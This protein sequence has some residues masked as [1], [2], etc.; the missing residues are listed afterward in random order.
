M[1]AST[2]SDP[3]LDKPWAALWSLVIG[4]FMILVDS[5][6]V[7]I[8]MP[9]IISGLGTDLNG[10]IWVTSAYLLAYVVP[11]LIT[12]RL[13]D[14]IGP[15]TMYLTG[16]AV[17]TASSLACGLAP[18]LTVMIIARV[19]QG[20]GAACMTPQTMTAITR[21]F[22]GARRGPAMAVWGA[23]A[24]VAMLVGP[25]LGGVLTDTLGWSWIF[26][27]N[28]PVGVAG[29]ALVARNVP[30]FEL[31]S[32]AFDLVGVGLSAVAMFLLVFGI[33]EGA[34][35]DWRW[36]VWTMIG[37]GLAML[38]VFVWWQFRTEEPLIPPALFA[39]RNFTLSNT[40]IACMGFAVTGM[41][42][43][44]ILY[45][46]LVRGLSPL[47]AALMLIPMA[48]ASL[49]MA[50]PVGQLVGRVHPRW[51]ASAGFVLTALGLVW[52]WAWLEPTRPLWMFLLPNFLV[53]FGSSL[54][55]SPLATSATFNL[56]MAWAG[57]GS[58]VY[59][60]TR[61]VGSVLGSAGIAAIM[62][63][64]INAE[65]SGLTHGA[66]PGGHATT[67]PLPEFLHTAYTNAMATSMLLPT[68]ALV[69]GG[70][71]SLGF[72]ALKPR[73]SPDP[74]PAEQAS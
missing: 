19:A 53:G 38:T 66:A 15:K 25:I 41:T 18:N 26:F 57:A 72:E 32:H 69:L 48:V 14:R 40:A 12:G 45:L 71:I 37:A 33:Q 61:Q 10:G 43:P 6:I 54:V 36:P 24:G 39:D 46:Q 4:F 30:R 44:F 52:F 34:S 20:L 60:T 2:T 22:P 49:I 9:E 29:F 5:T 56:P 21:M 59:N 23:T 63:S 8:A 51:L 16:L 74:Q 13:G 47:R 62:V 58:G 68:A 55:W 1:T 31:H 27:I 73:H 35:F 7:T 42:L 11:L 3:R 28:V 65:F 67:G 50:R 64:R 70:V 17:F